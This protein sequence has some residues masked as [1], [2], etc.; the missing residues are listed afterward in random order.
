MRPRSPVI[1][2]MSAGL[3]ASM[4]G[5]AIVLSGLDRA[6]AVAPVSVLVVVVLVTASVLVVLH[7]EALL[8][9]L[10]AS[11]P[12]ESKLAYPSA[13]VTVVAF[14]RVTLPALFLA[15]AF[16]RRDRLMAPR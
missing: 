3:A 5:G 6:L 8:L 7:P 11:L 1:A 12:W 16:V 15:R 14:I 4:L 13:T 9:V 10:V 2:P